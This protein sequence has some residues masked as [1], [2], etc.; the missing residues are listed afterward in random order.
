MLNVYWLCEAFSDHVKLPGTNKMLIQARMVYINTFRTKILQN[1]LSFSFFCPQVYE[2]M[3]RPACTKSFSYQLTRLRCSIPYQMGFRHVLQPCIWR[4]SIIRSAVLSSYLALLVCRTT[5]GFH[6]ILSER[7]DVMFRNLA[8]REAG[9]DFRPRRPT[10]VTQTSCVIFVV[11]RLSLNELK[12]KVLEAGCWDLTPCIVV[13]RYVTSQK[14]NF[15][16]SAV[17]SSGVAGRWS[18][19]CILKTCVGN[20]VGYISTHL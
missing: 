8:L 12:D 17:R 13:E 18:C 2:M 20:E 6:S 1:L 14:T 16:T 11:G 3:L 5:V 10:V 15:V 9:F 4:N 19:C 7:L